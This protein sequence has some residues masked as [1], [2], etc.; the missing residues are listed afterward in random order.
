VSRTA[1]YPPWPLTAMA[2]RKFGYAHAFSGPEI[3]M[4]FPP[5][6]KSNN[7]ASSS[8]FQFSGVFFSPEFWRDVVE[9]MKLYFRWQIARVVRSWY[10]ATRSL[11]DQWRLRIIYYQ[12]STPGG[13]QVSCPHEWVSCFGAESPIIGNMPIEDASSSC[14]THKLCDKGGPAQQLFSIVDQHS[15]QASERG[16]SW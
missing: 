2:V 16:M 9:G 7:F 10:N 6:S 4:Y 11:I 8:G 13:H 3:E 5:H 1:V 12:Y 15:S 14:W